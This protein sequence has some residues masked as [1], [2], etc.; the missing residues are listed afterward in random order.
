LKGP[1]VTDSLW[2]NIATDDQSLVLWTY[3]GQGIDMEGIVENVM[4]KFNRASWTCK[5]TFGKTWD[6]VPEVV[7]R[8][9]IL[10]IRHMLTYCSTV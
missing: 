6:L 7:Y 2:T 10:V 5:D 3:S 9:Y 4:N 8:L 1:R